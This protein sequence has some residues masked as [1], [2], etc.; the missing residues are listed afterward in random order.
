[1]ILQSQYGSMLLSAISLVKEQVF[2]Y[3]IIS[4]KLFIIYH[5][6]LDFKLLFLSINNH[7]PKGQFMNV[8]QVK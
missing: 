4:C 1:M 7:H 6:L 3:Q 5:Y 2:R 8:A